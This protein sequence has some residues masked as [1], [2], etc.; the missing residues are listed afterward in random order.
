MKLTRLS[1]PANLPDDSQSDRRPSDAN[2]STRAPTRRPVPGIK[3]FID[4]AESWNNPKRDGIPG[5]DPID[6]SQGHTMV[7]DAGPMGKS[8]IPMVEPSAFSLATEINDLGQANVE[9]GDM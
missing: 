3:E 9:E 1:Q 2:S 7:A 5:V 4:P 8:M 6:P